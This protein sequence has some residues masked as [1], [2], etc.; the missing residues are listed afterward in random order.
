MVARL[1]AIG[2]L[3]PVFSKRLSSAKLSTLRRY[4]FPS[5]R[6]L[7]DRLF[8]KPASKKFPCDGF[9]GRNPPP[10][11]IA[12]RSELARRMF[13]VAGIWKTR[14]YDARSTKP[15][16]GKVYA[17]PARGLHACSLATRV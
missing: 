13:S 9:N 2:K 1:N 5:I 11:S 6:T 8:E 15:A 12:E 10:P 3:T 17:A 14:S 16:R 7:D 4:Q